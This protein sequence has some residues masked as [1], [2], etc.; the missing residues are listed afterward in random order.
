[1]NEWSKCWLMLKN[2]SCSRSQITYNCFAALL[3]F[4]NR[5]PCN[6]LIIRQENS[7]ASSYLIILERVSIFR[8]KFRKV[9]IF[10][11]INEYTI[12]DE[13]DLDMKVQWPN[14]LFLQI[15]DWKIP[16]LKKTVEQST[17]LYENYTFITIRPSGNQGFKLFPPLSN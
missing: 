5:K 11:L 10:F 9:I 14:P 17:F 8:P 2:F 4:L 6:F 3:T 16:W 12:P 7:V 1:M 15:I 13:K